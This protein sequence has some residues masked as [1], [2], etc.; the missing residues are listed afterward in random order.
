MSDAPKIQ[1]TTDELVERNAETRAA[2]RRFLGQTGLMGV[3]LGMLGSAGLWPTLTQAQAEPGDDNGGGDDNDGGRPAV[4]DE[5]VLN[6][7]LNL[8]YLEAE[9]YSRAVFGRGL[10]ATLTTGR[11]RRGEVTG[12]RRVPFATPVIRQYA[13]EIARDEQAHVEFLRTTLRSAAVA[14]PTINIESSFTVAARAAGLIGPG[15]VFDPYADE[16]SFLLGAFIFEDVGVT[17]YKGAAPLLNNRTFLE[18]AAGILAVEAYHAANLRTVLYGQGV[19]APTVQISNARDAL[20]G[21]GDLDQGIIGRGLGGRAS[22]VPS[23]ANGIAFSRTPPQVLNIV[24]LTPQPR[25]R[26]GFFPQGVNG[27]I[28]RSG[29]SA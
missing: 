5:A 22:I 8:E 27:V 26:G 10:P 3:T 13:V 17:A 18:A 20:D 25:L 23:D 6:F 4:T 16:V 24:F 28:R 29:N 12:G 21:P 15:E 11:G 1:D 2:R 9:F 7:A 19:R 14:R